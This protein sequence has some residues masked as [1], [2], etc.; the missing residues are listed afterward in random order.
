MSSY[1]SKKTAL[2]FIFTI[3]LIVSVC[4]FISSLTE[5]KKR[6]GINTENV[7]SALNQL[8]VLPYEASVS[9]G[10]GTKDG[11]KAIIK[12]SHY[13][14]FYDEEFNNELCF[15]KGIAT[16][17][18]LDFK[19]L[20]N[21]P[22]INYIYDKTKKI[23]ELNKLCIVLG[24]EHTI[25]LAP[26]KAHLEK[27]NNLSV[28]HFDAHSDLR[29]KYQNNL[30]SHACVMARVCEFLDPK[31]LIQVGIRA[32]S[33]EESKYIKSNK[34]NTFY[35]WK[36]KTGEYGD[37]W[38]KEVAK[39]LSKDVYV[40]FD[41]DYFDPSI[42]PS[43]GTPEPNGFQWD[44]TIQIFREMNKLGKRIVGFDVVELAPKKNIIHPN[45]LAAKLVYKL[46]NFAKIP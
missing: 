37:N 7:Y 34:I 31:K 12:A 14:E 21:R 27:Y 40:T 6:L 29:N 30:Y 46:L 28:L 2:V 20:K 18:E 17:K 1:V 35:A 8:V 43:T 19:K 22:A 23:L 15:E 33:I 3:S 5:E 25:S 38:Q 42:M 10:K 39:K 32:Q 24:G 36:I 26:I 9:Y 44:E 4:L 13:I 45:Y 16:I 11:P 41:V